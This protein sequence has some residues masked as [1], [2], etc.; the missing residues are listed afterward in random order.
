M[1]KPAL[2]VFTG[3][4]GSGKSTHARTL[5]RHLVERGISAKYVHQFEPTTQLVSTGRRRLWTGLKKVKAMVG[6]GG[7]GVGKSGLLSRFIGG[8]AIILAYFRTSRK[9]KGDTDT[10]VL[11]FDRYFHDD[12]LRAAFDFDYQ[13]PWVWGLQEALPQPDL[14]FYLDLPAERALQREKDG[15]LDPESVVRKKSLYDDWYGEASDL[16]WGPRVVRVET[17]RDREEV[18]EEISA[19]ALTML[20]GPVAPLT[21]SEEITVTDT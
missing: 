11:V 1:G 20:G 16:S 3:I 2:I 5:T 17:T 21:V 12:I 13:P 9:A 15:D 10:E 6:Y 18:E 14:V 8:A 4:D 19:L 7:P